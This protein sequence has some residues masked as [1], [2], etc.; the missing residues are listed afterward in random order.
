MAQAIEEEI[1]SGIFQDPMEQYLCAAGSRQ[2]DR[3]LSRGKSKRGFA[4]L[5]DRALYCKGSWFVSRDR[6][7][8]RKQKTNFRL[9]LSEFQG[10]KTQQRRKPLLLVLALVFLLLGPAVL[11]LDQVT[12]FGE[13]TVLNPVLDAVI[14][15]LLA[16]IFF[17]LYSIHRRSLLVLLH[18]N[19]ALGLDEKHVP[20]KEEKQLVR[21]LRAYLSS[22]ENN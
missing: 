19:G 18:T 22:V 5:S 1:R 21:Y 20:E 12:G 3:F 11:L 13:N 14:C 17:L 9:E 7:R 2:M 4:V 16:G 8:Y 10:M 15:L 6:R